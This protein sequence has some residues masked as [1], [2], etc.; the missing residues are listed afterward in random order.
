MTTDAI[1]ELSPT[2]VEAAST[3]TDVDPTLG[4]RLRRLTAD[5]GAALIE[6]AWLVALTCVPIY[7]NV[8]SSRSFEPDKAALLIVL[9]GVIAAAWLARV[10]AG[11]SL[12]PS[13]RPRDGGAGPLRDRDLAGVLLF[14]SAGA[15]LAAAMLSTALSLSPARSWHGSFFRQQGLATLLAYLTIAL[16]VVAYL[17]RTEQWR[18][19]VFAITLG[20]VPVCAYAIIQRAGLDT[21]GPADKEL[22]VG[23]TLGNPIFL[24]GY[25]ALAFFITICG[26]TARQAEG[27][28]GGRGLARRLALAAVALMQLATLVLS[29]SRGPLLGL[30]AGVFVLSLAWSLRARGARGTES[31][32]GWH[33][34][35]WALVIAAGVAAFGLLVL[36]AAPR[37]PLAGVRRLPVVGRLA[38]ALDP[39]VPTARVRLLIWRGVVALTTTAPPLRDAAGEEDRLHALRP[40]VGYGPDCFDL[41]FNRVFPPELGVVERRNSI[42]DRAHCETFD[43]LVGTGALGL[44]AWLALLAGGLAFGTTLAVRG[45]HDGPASLRTFVMA[46]AGVA[47]VTAT[48][49]LLD[50]PDLAG[51]LAPAGLLAGVCSGMVRTGLQART[52]APLGGTETG[53]LL[54]VI[55]ALACHVVEVSVG[56][57]VTSSRLLFWFL[58][59]ALVAV[60]LNR[61]DA[62]QPLGE[63]EDASHG[64]HSQEPVLAALLAGVALAV[65]VYTLM[66]RTALAAAQAFAAALPASVFAGARAAGGFLAVIV[67]SA[68]AAAVTLWAGGSGGRYSRGTRIAVLAAAALPALALGALKSHRLAVTGHMQRSGAGIEELSVFVAGHAEVFCAA[69][70]A[71][72][73]L[74]AALL[75]RVERERT[76]ATTQRLAPVVLVNAV[77]LAFVAIVTV[78]VA[79]Q[80]LAPI[81]ADTFAK[82]AAAVIENNQ[83]VPALRLLVRA[84]WLAPGEP[85]LLTLVARAT[86]LASRAPLSAAGRQTAVAAGVGA[87]ELAGRMQ[88]FDP[89]HAVNLGRVLT[90]AAAIAPD[91]TA[92]RA[93]LEGAERAYARGLELRPGSVLFRVEHA[94]ILAHLGRDEAAAAELAAVVAVDPG[95]DTGALMLASL[96]HARAVT[97]LR[98]GREAEARSHLEN[99]LRALQALLV[100]AGGHPRAERAVAAL[101]ARLGRGDEAVA[102]LEG[103]VNG[104]EPAEVHEMLALLHLEAGRPTRAVEEAETALRVAG[105]TGRPRAEATLALVRSRTGA[106]P[107]A[108]ANT[109]P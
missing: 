24:G 67:V 55:S 27:G 43:L 103:L 59:A 109:K 26:L 39:S 102:V 64:S 89:D 22:R 58:L 87:L 84:S 69:V 71:I 14:A 38:A 30:S 13:V 1:S 53:L 100:H 78:I 52:P 97:A 86:V 8:Y 101:Y 23:S 18:R 31:G 19:A 104:R 40:L 51:A 79:R 7:F 48:T 16:A 10:L 9:A 25:V 91:A 15:F 2:P 50:R 29:Q 107:P 62:R 68:V 96:E 37:T 106:A 3:G 44:G 35:A 72:T 73:F 5:L 77:M 54:A 88:P 41:A 12:W 92:Q 46:L 63:A 32:G 47:A 82:H 34:H 11:G 60:S 21:I 83:P 80:A 42:P 85:S 66:D 94:G 65:A 74:L 6:A 75:V 17:R 99:A 93:L 20:S 98:A 36:L 108:G 57:P 33:R 61:L 105:T 90:S 95:Y 49:V 45:G 28:A 56:I 81:R 4:Q 70:V 76:S